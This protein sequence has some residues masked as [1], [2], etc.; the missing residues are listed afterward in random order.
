MNCYSILVCFVVPAAFPILPC[1]PEFF[2]LSCVET[3][4]TLAELTAGST[5]LFLARKMVQSGSDCVLA[6]GFEK[7]RTNL[8]QVYQDNGW[9]SPTDHLFERFASYAFAVSEAL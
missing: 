1:Y 7:M 8:S 3:Y 5:A 2:V 4:K 9:T 6:L